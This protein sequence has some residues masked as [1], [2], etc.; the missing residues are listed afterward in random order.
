MSNVQKLN[1]EIIAE[2]AKLKGFNYDGNNLHTYREWI[3]M[4]YAIVRG[5][6]AYLHCRLWTLG[7]NRRKVPA[8]LF[9]LDQVVKMNKDNLI[10]V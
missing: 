1:A 6:K 2:A 5:Q 9:S 8:S 3:D 7:K 4:G 10:V